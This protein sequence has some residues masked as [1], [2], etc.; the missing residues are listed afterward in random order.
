MKTDEFESIL[1]TLAIT[2]AKATAEYFAT[3]S[4]SILKILPKEDM[5]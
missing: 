2:G 4:K 3:L 1:N 5:K